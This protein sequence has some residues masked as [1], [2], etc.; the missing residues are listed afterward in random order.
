[1]QNAS[2]CAVYQNPLNQNIHI[3]ILHTDLHT[4]A[5]SISWENLS[6]D[7]SKFPLV[8]I[9]FFSQI[10]KENVSLTFLINI[11]QERKIICLGCRGVTF[12]V[13]AVNT[14][15]QMALIFHCWVR[16]CNTIAWRFGRSR[17]YSTTENKSDS[18]HY[19]DCNIHKQVLQTFPKSSTWNNLF[20][21][22]KPF[23]FGDHCTTF[24]TFSVIMSWYC[25][26]KINIGPFWDS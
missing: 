20:K 9:F 16:C 19:I 3:Q 5:K 13:V 15:V 11:L 25:Y 18:H 2:R 23:H 8:I 14:V 1:M 12:D 26:E 4:F 7:R 24:I 6:K 10:K 22:S 21:R 17:L